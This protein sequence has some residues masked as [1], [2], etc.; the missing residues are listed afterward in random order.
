MKVYR[1]IKECT[2]TCRSDLNLNDFCLYVGDSIF[3]DFCGWTH[4]NSPHYG[5][6]KIRPVQKL[7][8][9]YYEKASFHKPRN[10]WY[11][12][13]NIIDPFINSH[14]RVTDSTDDSWFEFFKDVTRE[15]KFKRLLK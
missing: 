5:S 1:T 8:K 13:M 3:V 4:D 2:I 7:I 12:N 9:I 6:E 15:H 10:E 11:D 14:L